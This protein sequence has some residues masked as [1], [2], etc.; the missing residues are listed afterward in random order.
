MLAFF[1]NMEEPIM[2]G[3][4]PNPDPFL[5][6]PSAKQAERQNWL[7]D[8]I[9]TAQEKVDAKIPELDSKQPG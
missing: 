1:N 2:D 7:K 5:K 8:S 9:A 4:K 6:I 3:N